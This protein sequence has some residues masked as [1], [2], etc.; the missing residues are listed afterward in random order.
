MILTFLRGVGGADEL[1]AMMA[2]WSHVPLDSSLST[3]AAM[4]SPLVLLQVTI[5]GVL[6][7]SVLSFGLGIVLV[8]SLPG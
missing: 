4:I 8:L 2:S 1:Q 7:L 6:V 5:V 3:M